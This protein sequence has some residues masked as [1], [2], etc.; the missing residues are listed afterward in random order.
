VTA[1]SVTEFLIPILSL[2]ID[3]VFCGFTSSDSSCTK[4]DVIVIAIL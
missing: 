1:L 4:C 2:T 3:S